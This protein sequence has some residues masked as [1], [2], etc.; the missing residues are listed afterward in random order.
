VINRKTP[1]ATHFLNVDLDIYSR[2]NLQPLLTAMGKRVSILHAQRDGQ[3]FCAHLELARQTKSADSTIRGLC[4]LVRALPRAE[5]KLWNA[6]KVRDFN[7]GVQAEM[8]PFSYEIAIA[9]ET[10]KA[11]SDVNARI[12]FTVYAPQESREGS[13][14]VTLGSKQPT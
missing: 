5:G 10:V 7:I 11:V 14:D 8:Q 1:E 2:S 4:A 3:T 12:V 13:P 6:A 9:A